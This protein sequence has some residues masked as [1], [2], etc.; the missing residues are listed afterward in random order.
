MRYKR[1]YDLFVLLAAHLALLPVWLIAWTVIPL[2]IWLEDRGPVFYRQARAGKG[3][4]DFMAIKFRTMKVNADKMG[5][6]TGDRDPRVTRVGGILRRTALDELPQVINIARGEMSFV[7]PR[8]LPVQMH[9]DETRVE[10]RFPDRLRMT[11]GLTGIAQLYLPRHCGPKR[12]LR[13]DMLY[14]TRASLWLDI[15]IMLAAAVNTITASWG[16][17]EKSVAAGA[18]TKSKVRG[19]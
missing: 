9:E 6:V 18:G 2:A 19:T 8:A 5:L 17:G 16:T 3:R 10:P 7:G 12:R 13:Y 14:L 11:P 15:R 4:K 1:L